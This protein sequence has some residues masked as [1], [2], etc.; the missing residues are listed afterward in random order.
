MI[1]E[2][3]QTVIDRISSRLSIGT[4]QV[5]T[6]STEPREFLLAVADQFGLRE[7]AENLDKPNIGKLIVEA[8][9]IKW[10]PDFD[11]SGSTIT[12]AGLLAIEEVVLMVTN[13]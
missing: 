12:K 5:S 10:Q 13:R 7:Q 11:S 6:G 9:G 1:S 2:T 3:K 8:H 4:F